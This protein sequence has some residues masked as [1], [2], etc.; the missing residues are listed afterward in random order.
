MAGQVS[1]PGAG[2]PPTPSHVMGTTWH[3]AS[4]R[5]RK[6]VLVCKMP[7][8]P[9]PPCSCSSFRRTVKSHWSVFF[10]KDINSFY[11]TDKPCLRV[12]HAYLQAQSPGGSPLSARGLAAPSRG[13]LSLLSD[14][15]GGREARVCHCCSVT[16]DYV[17]PRR[18]SSTTPE[19]AQAQCIESV[20][21]SNHLILCHP[22]LLPSIFPSFRVFSKESVLCIRWPKC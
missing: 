20:M 22:L 8:A 2:S 18:P 19:L 12:S 13:V 4:G 14:L 9:C 16:S 3:L 21:P 6:A 5:T 15:H 7:Q 1:L 11:G 17:L 10:I